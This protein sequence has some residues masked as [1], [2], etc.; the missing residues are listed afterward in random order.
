MN[1][2]IIENKINFDTICGVPYTALPISTLVS[3]KS[4]KPMVLR[5]K[6]I[7]TYGTKQLIDGKFEKGNHCIIIEDVI[8]TGSSILETIAVCTYKH[9]SLNF[10]III[11]DIFSYNKFKKLLL[12]INFILSK[13]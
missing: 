8:S 7:K 5:R 10:N 3:V 6:E 11:L 12:R 2:T 1:D 9:E 4:K 13:F